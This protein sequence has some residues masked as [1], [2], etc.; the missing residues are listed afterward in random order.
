VGTAF[1][2]VTAIQNFGL[3]VAPIIVGVLHDN[4]HGEKSYEWV[5]FFFVMAGA[6]GVVSAIIIMVNDK[7]TG[8]VL[9]S[10]NPK[11]AY[12]KYM[13]S[14]KKITPEEDLLVEG[15]FLERSVRR[16]FAKK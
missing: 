5:S 9:N 6:C 13:I 1:G 4:T 16:S 12:K 14:L 10:K 7:K 11:E 2:I 8:N 3:A 15:S